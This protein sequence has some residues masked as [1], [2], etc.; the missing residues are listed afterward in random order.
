MLTII[1]VS[2]VIVLTVGC[3]NHPKTLIFRE[4]DI[5]AETEWVKRLIIDGWYIDRVN[6]VNH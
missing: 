1:V 4:T 5:Y 6:L 2:V 3:C